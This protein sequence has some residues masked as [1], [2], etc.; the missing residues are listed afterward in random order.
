MR[1]TVYIGEGI[2]HAKGVVGGLEMSQEFFRVGTDDCDGWHGE[3]ASSLAWSGMGPNLASTLNYITL[4]VFILHCTWSFTDKNHWHVSRPLHG[5][6]GRE[7]SHLH[8]TLL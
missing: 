6:D 5:F 4:P 7:R 1:G 3:A 2:M 8:L